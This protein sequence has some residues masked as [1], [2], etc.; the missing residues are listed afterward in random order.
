MSLICVVVSTD[1]SEVFR[2]VI[3]LFVW[4]SDDFVSD[5]SVE[6]FIK[7]ESVLLLRFTSGRDWLVLCLSIRPVY[8]T[9]Q[10][11]LYISFAS[12]MS[13]LIWIRVWD[14]NGW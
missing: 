12:I 8:S 11:L 4:M 10:S 14:A 6:F 9:Q 7:R 2:G 3:F 5:E 13:L 1:L